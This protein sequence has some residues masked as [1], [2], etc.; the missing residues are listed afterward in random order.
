MLQWAMWLFHIKSWVTIQLHIVKSDPLSPKSDMCKKCLMGDSLASAKISCS[1]VPDI[2]TVITERSM[3]ATLTFPDGIIISAFIEALTPYHS[4]MHADT[5]TSFALWT[6]GFCAAWICCPR[7]TERSA[8]Q[9]LFLQDNLPHALGGQ[10]ARCVEKLCGQRN[11]FD[12]IVIQGDHA[13]RNHTPV[14]QQGH[15]PPKLLYA[16]H[17]SYRINSGESNAGES[18]IGRAVH[19]DIVLVEDVEYLSSAL[20][21]RVHGMTLCQDVPQRVQRIV[22]VSAVIPSIQLVLIGE[23][24]SYLIN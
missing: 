13:P 18:V 3:I 16:F 17:F 23:D 4:T 11:Q 6:S 1:I 10:R 14:F 5:S 19:H 9:S 15:C 21:H 12:N 22:D 24:N 8:S 7:Y 20:M 2:N